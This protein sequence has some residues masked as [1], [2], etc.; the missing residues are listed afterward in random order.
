MKNHSALPPPP[1]TLLSI[2]IP[3]PLFL[4]HLLFRHF[5]ALRHSTPQ[6]SGEEASCQ[7]RTHCRSPSWPD[8]TPLAVPHIFWGIKIRAFLVTIGK[9]A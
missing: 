7:A 3:P 6:G 9:Q 8:N 4:K 2:P 1:H 5:R